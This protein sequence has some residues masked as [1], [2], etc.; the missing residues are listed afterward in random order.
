MR[1][2]FGLALAAGLALASASD[3]KAQVVI[4]TGTT[5]G[6]PG[7]VAPGV[8]SYYRSGYV[9]VAPAY[10]YP[11]VGGPVVGGP[12]YYRSGYVG[13]APAVV[14]PAYR[15]PAYGY[16]YWGGVRRVPFGVARPYRYGY[17]W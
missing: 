12:L 5:Y 17:G 13:V 14:A 2:L 6:Y 3:A 15:Y 7:L 11:V 4:T 1:K 10:G 16:G 8:P 9:G